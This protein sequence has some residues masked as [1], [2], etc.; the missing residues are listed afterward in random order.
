MRRTLIASVCLVA[1]LGAVTPA[2]AGTSAG[3]VL[4]PDRP[5]RAHPALLVLLPSSGETAAGYLEAARAAQRAADGTGLWVAIGD[6]GSGPG[7]ALLQYERL[8]AQVRAAGFQDLR[9]EHVVVAAWADAVPGLQ[10]IVGAHDVAGT[11]ALGSGELASGAGLRVLG[12]LDRSSRVVR[13]AL[14]PGPL[15]VL[16][17]AGAAGLRKAAAGAVLGDLAEAHFADAAD[18]ELRLA[19]DRLVAAVRSAA[20]QERGS[21]CA[22]LQRT[23]ADLAAAD[24]G[25]LVV[26]NRAAAD[27]VAPTPAGVAQGDLGGFLYDKAELADDGDTARVTTNS[28]TPPGQPAVE[29]MCKTKSRSAIAQAIYGSHLQVDDT[30]PACAD[31]TR[32][33]LDW[34]RA[35][36]SPTAARRSAGVTVLPDLPKSAGP[37]WVFSPLVLR[38]ADPATGRWEVQSPALVTQLSDTQL[39][40]TFAGNHYCKVLSPV[41]ALELILE[42]TVPVQG[43][44]S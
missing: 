30:P 37:E 42:D 15:L 16:P 5:G 25:R 4:V 39:D 32:G 1:V 13:T 6:V 9:D 24:A 28:Y 3:T 21:V 31:F 10:A 17:E 8:T 7:S 2:G 26:Q 19:G 12:E 40:P 22:D 33:T 11:A 14:T 36:V 38:P 20:E 35:Q 29:V 44:R 18:L 41:R 43:D 23:T 27:L 34:A